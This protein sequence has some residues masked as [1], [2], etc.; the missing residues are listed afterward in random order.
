[1]VA[2]VPIATCGLGPSATSRS[3]RTFWTLL[4][5]VYVAAA[6]NGVQAGLHVEGQL[7]TIV[8]GLV[9]AASMAELCVLHARIHGLPLPESFQWILFIL[10]P[11]AV[12]VYFV[13]ARGWK[14]FGYVALHAVLLFAV[15]W[16]SAIATFFVAK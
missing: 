11:F 16:A 6:I 12:P 2:N 15:T 1:V 14:G 4:G 13:W 7:L 3:T 5:F 8:L 10:W 9:V